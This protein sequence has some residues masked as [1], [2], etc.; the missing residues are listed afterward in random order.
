M[1][2]SIDE[3]RD[4]LNNALLA[5]DVEDALWQFVDTGL[6]D[7]ILPELP[8]LRLEQD[9]IHQHCRT[10]LLLQQRHRMISLFA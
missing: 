6:A 8:A 9:P 1:K 2:L 3:Q 10:L 5:E 7:E 4:I